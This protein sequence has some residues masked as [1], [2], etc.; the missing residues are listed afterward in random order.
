MSF[1]GS[2]QYAITTPQFDISLTSSRG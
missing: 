1:E 2:Q